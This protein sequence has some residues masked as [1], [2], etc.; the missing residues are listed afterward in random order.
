MAGVAADVATAEGRAALLAAV[1]A[2][3]G[4]Q[5]DALFNN[6]GTNIRKP[7]VEYSDADFQSLVSTNLESAFAMS[8]G[9]HPLLKAAG[10]G[11]VVMNSSV[12]GGPTS[13]RS[14]SIYAMTK[15]AMVGP[16][17]LIGLSVG[18]LMTCSTGGHACLKI[19]SKSAHF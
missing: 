4:G 14:G 6:V 16:C 1:G 2:A 5:L 17:G 19:K 3:F 11:V 13:M 12:A 9:V 10:G 7:S 8:R 15:A 18:C